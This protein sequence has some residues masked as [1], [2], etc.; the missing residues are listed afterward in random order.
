M[1]TLINSYFLKKPAV[2]VLVLAL[3]FGLFSCSIFNKNSKSKAETLTMNIVEDSDHI[4]YASL[5]AQ[6]IPSFAARGKARG[7]PVALAGGAISLATDAVKKVIADEQKKYVADYTFALTDLYFYDQLAE[8]SPF[9]PVGM[10]FNGFRI[11]RL[12]ENGNDGRDTAMVVDFELDT[13]NPYE[14][15]N[16]SIFRLKLKRIDIKKLKAK[17]APGSQ[18][19]ANL[20]IEIS[21]RTSYVNADGQLFD[22]LELGKFYFL[23]RGAPVGEES[24]IK[25][26][27]FKS[28]SGTR[29]DGKSFIVPRSFGY[30]IAAPGVTEP[31]FSQGAYSITVSVKES[32]KDNFV[33]KIISDNSENIIEMLGKK[34]QQKIK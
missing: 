29:L 10:Q 12:V 18:N 13:D 11:A 6:E 7:F 34:A 26:G 2:Y 30:R 15:I 32:T 23:L 20:D 17:M 28:L 21:I 16:N 27:Y 1:R 33:N 4:A 24:E 22:N 5:Q 19:K 31:A 3:G 8:D 14:I 9:D 25:N